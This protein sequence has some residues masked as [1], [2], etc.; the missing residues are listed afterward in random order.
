MSE[1]ERERER[2]RG[3][4]FEGGSINQYLFG[5][6]GLKGHHLV[7]RLQPNRTNSRKRKKKARKDFCNE[8]VTTEFFGHCCNP[9][10]RCD[11]R[12]GEAFVQLRGFYGEIN[13]F[14]DI[15][16]CSVGR[17]VAS[18]SRGPWFESGQ[19]QNLF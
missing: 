3:T 12:Q 11:P 9:F 7:G 18:V 6:E 19:W 17:A 15:G 13:I 1:K 5:S 8:I 4:G 16:C 2:E 14:Q 10:R